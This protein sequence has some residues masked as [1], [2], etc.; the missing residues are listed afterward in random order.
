MDK[1]SV[2]GILKDFNERLPH[3]SDGRINYSNSD[4]APTVVAFLKYK[5]EMLV[6]KRSNKVRTHEGKWS[7]VA[8][9]LDELKPV[10]K[11]IIEEIKE[12]TGIGEDKIRSL[13]MGEV[14]KFYDDKKTWI[15]H[16]FLIELKEKPEVELDWEHTD[17]EWVK[18]EKAKRYLS[19]P[20]SQGLSRI[21]SKL[22]GEVP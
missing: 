22:T 2:P 7:V 20:F 21:L 18:I 8:G 17:F 9:Y 6:L 1:K 3:F 19:E 10:S 12:E 5:N 14:R 16:P 15:S 13:K 11:K 4:E